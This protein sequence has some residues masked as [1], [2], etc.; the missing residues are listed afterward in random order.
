MPSQ[1]TA[2]PS[3]QLQKSTEASPEFLG[4]SPWI[5]FG[6]AV[7]G[8]VAVFALLMWFRGRLLRPKG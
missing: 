8:M 2:S 5:A 6:V 4:G 3:V 1:V 7:L